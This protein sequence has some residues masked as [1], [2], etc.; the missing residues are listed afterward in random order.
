[1]GQRRGI[2][3]I[4]AAA[5]VC[6][7]LAGVGAY[8]AYAILDEDVF[9]DR[10]ASTLKSDEVR[11]EVA[12]RIAARAVEEQPSLGGD[13]AAVEDA[14]LTSVV[15]DPG[16]APAFRAAAAR[17]H[18][19]VLSGPEDDGALRVAGSGATLKAALERLPGWGSLPQIK[20][21]WLLAVE[22]AGHDRP[23]RR[24]APTA[25]DVTIPLTI[26]FAVLGAALLALGIAR[27]A[28]RRR[29][30]WAAGI[31]V[32][33]AGGLLAAGITG[34]SDVVLD[35]FDTGFGDAVVSQIWRAYFGDLRIW[36]LA[37]GAVGLVVAAAAG[38]PRLGPRTLLATPA[39]RSGRLLRAGGLLA[40]AAVAVAL[41]EMVLHIALVTL[42][43]GLVYVAAGELLRVLAPPDCAA[44]AFR[45]VGA[46]TALVALIVVATVGV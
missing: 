14:A 3:A 11:Q 37:I 12:A 28:T 32:A 23:L 31:T 36:A 26:F 6:L 33:M 18:R 34:A 17:M 35:Q 9:A 39:S 16:F 5:A 46:T 40:L 25:A 4:L 41:P 15:A 43:A 27:A 7:L 30:V 19:A 24:L 2:A 1:M 10:A 21:P 8:C 29:G 44:R 13:E 20:D 38:G 22:D 42:A 45:A